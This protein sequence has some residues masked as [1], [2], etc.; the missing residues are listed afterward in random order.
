MDDGRR[1]RPGDRELEQ[2]IRSGIVAVIGAFVASLLS[3]LTSPTGLSLVFLVW[4]ATILAG[5]TCALAL[6]VGL[7][8]RRR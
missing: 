2:A 5:T 3:G 4:L 1:S 7:Y 8:K 6:A